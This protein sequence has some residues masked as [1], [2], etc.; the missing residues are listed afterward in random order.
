MST[1]ADD[2]VKEQTHRSPR[3]LRPCLRIPYLVILSGVS[4]QKL[5]DFISTNRLLMVGG[6]LSVIY[7]A[8][9]GFGALVLQ[10]R[11]LRGA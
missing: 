10:K 4:P 5:T 1:H 3:R 9:N 6:W 2:Y 8:T 7:P 11:K